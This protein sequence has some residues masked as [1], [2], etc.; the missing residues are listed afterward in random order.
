MSVGLE[1]LDTGAAAATRETPLLFVHGTSHGAWCWEE[2][3]LR[4]FAD[5][6]YRAAAVNLR[7]HGG[8]PLGTALRGV[9]LADFADDLRTAVRALGVAPVLIGHSLGGFVVA[10]YLER[11]DVPGAV[12]IASAP[13]HG[14]WGTLS[15]AVRHQ[16]GV[17]GK[18]VLRG[19]LAPDFSAPEL[20]RRWFFS[21]DL[22]QE[23][24][25]RYAARLQEESDRALLDCLFGRPARPRRSIPMLVLA[26]GDDFVFSP[27]ETAATA[28]A[29]RADWQL[30]PNLAHD[31]MLD[32]RWR[33]AADAIQRWLQRHRF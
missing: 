14:S 28:R 33:A 3:F 32:T 30:I 24:V 11:H 9:S 5:H 31:A 16:P 12:L 10:R 4:Y 19:R 18:T 21:P 13:P 6:G 20:A 1:I 27:R 26:A 8:S 23:L 7:G 15:R 2:H 17:M 25:A 22:P 29:Y